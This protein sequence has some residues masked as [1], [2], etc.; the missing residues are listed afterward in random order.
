M[1]RLF[2]AAALVL[3][4]AAPASAA[5]QVFSIHFSVLTDHYTT[6]TGSW[7]LTC[8]NATASATHHGHYVG[9]TPFREY[10]LET[11]PSPTRCNL[12]VRAWN[13]GHPHGQRPQVFTV[14]QP[15]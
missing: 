8:S 5:P 13:S 9:P 10:V 2:L 7:T 3:G 1:R 15:L 4:L 12:V 14:V 6:V 11:I